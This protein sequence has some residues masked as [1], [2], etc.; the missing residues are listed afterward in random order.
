MIARPNEDDINETRELWQ[1]IN[2]WMDKFGLTPEKLAPQVKLPPDRIKKGLRGE[3]VPV[4]DNIYYFAL[5]FD[6]IGIY[7]RKEYRV[8]PI[9]I[10]PSYDKLKTMLKPQPQG[11]LWVDWGCQ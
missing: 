11:K 5:A 2:W 7:Y 6:L 10:L 4:K 8:N 3:Y 9:D 1:Y